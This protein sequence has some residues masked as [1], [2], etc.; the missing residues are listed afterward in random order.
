LAVAVEVTDLRKSYGAVEAVR[1][2][3]HAYTR[4]EFSARFHDAFA[5]NLPPEFWGA[6]G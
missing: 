1:T 5:T 4:E 2:I 3:E 6:A